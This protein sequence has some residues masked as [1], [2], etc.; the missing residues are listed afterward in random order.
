MH[1]QS[2]HC[3]ILIANASY[4]NQTGPVRRGVG[5][6]LFSTTRLSG[7]LVLDIGVPYDSQRGRQH[8]ACSVR[9]NRGGR[10]RQPRKWRRKSSVSK[11]A[12]VPQDTTDVTPWIRRLRIASDIRRRL[13]CANR[14]HLKEKSQNTRI[15]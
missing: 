10:I 3:S 5:M 1:D 4:A 9:P 12:C 7:R 13:L 11:I 15:V 2:K 6:A 14:S 8:S